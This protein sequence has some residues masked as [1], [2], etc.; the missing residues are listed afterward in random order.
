M[1]ST[2]IRI[3][4]PTTIAARPCRSTE[5]RAQRAERF[6]RAAMPLTGKVYPAAQRPTSRQCG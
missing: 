6:E 4:L 3:D 1:T 5:T 2:R